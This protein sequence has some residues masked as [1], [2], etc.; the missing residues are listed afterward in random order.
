MYYSIVLSESDSEND[1]DFERYIIDSSVPIV[2]GHHIKSPRDTY[3]VV[4][5]VVHNTGQVRDE[6][7]PKEYS[8]SYMSTTVYASRVEIA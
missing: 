8:L 1:E 7:A 4:K 2:V 6:N 5:A 3:Y